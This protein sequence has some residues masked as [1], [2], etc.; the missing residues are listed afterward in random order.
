MTFQSGDLGPFDYMS[1]I[2]DAFAQ[3]ERLGRSSMFAGKKKKAKIGDILGSVIGHIGD[4]LSGNN[5]YAQS[6]KSRADAEAAKADYE[7]K[8]KDAQDWW[9]K[10]QEH[11]VKNKSP[12]TI[13]V[14]GIVLNKKTMQPVW[15][16]PYPKVIP[17]PDGS[18]YEIPRKG[19]GSAQPPGLPP[20]A[21][22]QA[23]GVREQAIDAIRRGANPTEV[24]KRLQ[25]LE[26]GA[27]QATGPANFSRY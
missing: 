9:Y 27:G 15:E 18:F 8:L 12:D 21:P 17:G 10:Q 13:E 23:G 20:S 16:S 26:G 2:N 5:A 24:L 25:Q 7:R 19:L 3:N 4:N 6:V 1:G 14:D 22:S 11:E